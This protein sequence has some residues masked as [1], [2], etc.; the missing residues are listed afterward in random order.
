VFLWWHELLSLIKTEVNV[1]EKMEDSGRE[2]CKSR[3][4]RCATDAFPAGAI[5]I[6][7]KLAASWFF[8]A[9]RRATNSAARRIF[10]VLLY[11]FSSSL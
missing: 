2:S 7:A 5:E 4:R 11:R 8:M 3:P 9:A 10:Q 6:P 1:G